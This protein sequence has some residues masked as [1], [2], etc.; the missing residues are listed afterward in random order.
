MGNLNLED[1]I[2]DRGSADVSIWVKPFDLSS[3]KDMLILFKE[4]VLKICYV[5]LCNDNLLHRINRIIG[6]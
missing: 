3:S 4:I 1:V 6:Y 5:L 2:L